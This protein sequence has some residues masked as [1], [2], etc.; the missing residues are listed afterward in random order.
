MKRHEQRP[1]ERRMSRDR[2][3]KKR[4]KPFNSKPLLNQNIRGEEYGPKGNVF[5]RHIDF[6]HGVTRWAT[7]LGGLKCCEL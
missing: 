6:A 4:T 5:G 3:V 1:A 2:R 7:S